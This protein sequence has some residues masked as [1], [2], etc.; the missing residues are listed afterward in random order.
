M[1]TYL[2]R[3]IGIVS[4]TLA[5]SAVHCVY[6]K[7]DKRRRKILDDFNGSAR[8]VS[9]KRMAT[10]KA[11]N[12]PGQAAELW[13]CSHEVETQTAF[14]YSSVSTQ[15]CYMTVSETHFQS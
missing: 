12:W 10:K 14:P 13:M 15:L 3:I 7:P 11:I 4:L 8:G 2:P 9:T 6:T 1:R 5:T